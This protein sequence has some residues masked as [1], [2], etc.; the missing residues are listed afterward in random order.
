MNQIKDSFQFYYKYPEGDIEKDILYTAKKKDDNSYE[1]TWISP[2]LGKI[3]FTNYLNSWVES[4]LSE[5]IWVVVES[6]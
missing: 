5:E 4:A 1:V 3:A 6:E 2:G